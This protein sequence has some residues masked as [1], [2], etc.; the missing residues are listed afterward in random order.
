MN[1]R[2]LFTP[3]QQLRWYLIGFVIGCANCVFCAGGI[4]RFL[5]SGN[6]V[7]VIGFTIYLFG[8]GFICILVYPR[9]KMLRQIVA[10]EKK[11]K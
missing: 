9:I 8:Q 2:N 4:V 5:L 1:S 10:M 6:I 3:Q 7:A 11:K